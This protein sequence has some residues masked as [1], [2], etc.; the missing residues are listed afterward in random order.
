MPSDAYHLLPHEVKQPSE[1]VNVQ[2]SVFM[3]SAPRE[4]RDGRSV[5]ERASL[6]Q[7]RQTLQSVKCCTQRWSEDCANDAT[8][9]YLPVTVHVYFLGTVLGEKDYA[10]PP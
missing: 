6:D 9:N 5:H 3:C 8:N 2:H 1:A 7:L 4:V 10:L